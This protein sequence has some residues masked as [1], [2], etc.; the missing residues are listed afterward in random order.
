M[1]YGRISVKAGVGMGKASQTIKVVRRYVLSDLELS[2]DLAI[3]E[4]TRNKNTDFVYVLKLSYGFWP[5]YATV[6]RVRHGFLLCPLC[7]I[8]PA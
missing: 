6:L 1:Y 3:K 7:E 4:T 5:I 8:Q 2:S